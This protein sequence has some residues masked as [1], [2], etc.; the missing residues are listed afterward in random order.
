M[1]DFQLDYSETAKAKTNRPLNIALAICFGGLFL[2]FVG[3]VCG[4]VVFV[5]GGKALGSNL[6]YL[7]AVAAYLGF[8]V[9][10]LIGAA[11]SMELPDWKSPMPARAVRKV[12]PVNDAE[13]NFGAE[14]VGRALIF[15]RRVRGFV[16]RS[17]SSAWVRLNEARPLSELPEKATRLVQQPIVAARPRRKNSR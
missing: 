15:D 13:R 7:I 4:V 5:S 3:S 17:A 6:S 8:I 12:A 11:F 16:V 14:F 1:D 9:L 2:M 10:A